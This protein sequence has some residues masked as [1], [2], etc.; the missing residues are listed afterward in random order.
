MFLY[1]F[2]LALLV[3][4]T[5]FAA[6]FAIRWAKIIFLLEDDLSEAIEIH[7]RTAATLEGIL[8]TPMFFDSPEIKR[9]ATEALDNVKVCQTATQKL[10]YNFTQRS[11]QRYV[12]IE[13]S[14]E[15][16]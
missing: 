16:E 14:V 7:E 5:G 15:S 1:V 9:A 11:K 13:E 4:A 10:V 3:V 8:K 2:L 12:R 6:F